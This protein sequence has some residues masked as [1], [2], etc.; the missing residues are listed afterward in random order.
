MRIIDVDALQGAVE[1][2]ILDSQRLLPPDVAQ[3]LQAAFAVESSPQGADVLGQLLENAACAAQSGLPLCQDTGTFVF[4]VEVGEELFLKGSLHKMLE[5]ATA[6]A[7]AKGYLRASL[8]H[9][10]S[11][12]NTGN[13]TPPAI[14]FEQTPGEGLR[15]RFLPKGGGAENMSRLA[16]LT[17]AKGRQ[18]IKDFVLQSVREA[19]PNPCPPIIVGVAI[20]AS[21][22]MA[23]ALAKKAL[24]R[25]LDRPAADGE[26]AALEQELK[27]EINALHI[28]PG[29]LGGL[30][31]CLGVRVEM[32]PCHIA[33]LP[34]AVNIQ[35]NSARR[36]E[37]VL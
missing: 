8:C 11:R 27:E 3:A 23:P 28:G 34:V 20:G 15:I 21:F 25:P 29:G 17:P 14:H 10:L 4:F 37:L 9:P 18:G 33:C 22:D 19:G 30:C 7:C 24:L 12:A 1:A 31:T 6:S 36:G 26:A 16:M 13:N 35:C 5:R 2:M 32:H